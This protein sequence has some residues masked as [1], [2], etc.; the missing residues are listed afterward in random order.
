MPMNLQKNNSTTNY[1]NEFGVESTKHLRAILY[2]DDTSRLKIKTNVSEIGL[3]GISFI[4][5]FSELTK[6]LIAETK[7]LIIL[8]GY[9]NKANSVSDLILYKELFDLD[10]FCLGN[11]EQFKGRL[12]GIATLYSC[13]IT[14]LDFDLV[15][16]AVYGD[17]TLAK[18]PEELQI[19]VTQTTNRDLAK[20]ILK[21]TVNYNAGLRSLANEYLSLKDTLDLTITDRD[22]YKELYEVSDAKNLKLEK[23]NSKFVEGYADIV[24]KVFKLNTS[25]KTYES[26]LSAD[27]YEKV[28]LTKYTNRPLIIYFKE[29][30]DLI[31]LDT[32]IE[33]LYYVFTNQYHKSVKVVRLYDSAKTRKL[34]TLPNYYYRLYN[35]F[36]SEE[37]IVHNFI[38]KTADYRKLFDVLLTNNF[39]IYVILEFDYIV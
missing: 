6:E 34:S 30:E 18:A 20:R 11:V 14:F 39:M 12:N 32:F 35:K 19:D 2:L 9:F 3:Y 15:Q 22:R 31:Y 4:N 8:E 1:D 28:D 21:D 37:A 7:T 25:L 29:F 33:T 36:T 24:Q 23:E 10:I 17:T 38:C 13:D 16:S 5:N 26:V 27:V